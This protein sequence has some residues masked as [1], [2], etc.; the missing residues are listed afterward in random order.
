MSELPTATITNVEVK[1]APSTEGLPRRRVTKQQRLF[2]AELIHLLRKHSV[3]GSEPL[4]A[5]ASYV[6]G[7][8]VAVQDPRKVS[9]AKADAIIRANIRHG[10]F[11]AMVELQQ[12][13]KLG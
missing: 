1:P 5:M 8:L 13:S 4:L 7:T 12:V 3:V 6:L 10:R 11:E 2:R 9:D